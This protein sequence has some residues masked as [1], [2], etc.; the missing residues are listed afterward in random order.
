MDTDRETNAIRIGDTEYLLTVTAG[1]AVH[2]PAPP[3]PSRPPPPPPLPPLLR[4]GRG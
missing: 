2:L 3:P 4:R 1:N